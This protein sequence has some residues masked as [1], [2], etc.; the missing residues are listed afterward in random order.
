MSLR[1]LSLI[2]S[3]SLS[4]LTLLSAQQIATD[5]DPTTGG[6]RSITLADDPSPMN[7]LAATDSVEMAAD[8]PAW[9]WGVLP[10]VGRQFQW[11]LGR[12][13]AEGTMT[14]WRTAQHALAGG[15]YVYELTPDVTLTVRRTDTSGELTETY[16]F[17]NDGTSAVSL[18]DIEINTPFA[19]NYPDAP[20]CLAERCHTHIWAGGS[21][22]YVYALHMGAQPM[23]LALQL[24]E[25]SISRYAQQEKSPLRGSSNTRGILCLC[26][27]DMKL[28]P[29]EERRVVWTLFAI[30]D[31]DDFYGQ[32][33][34][35]GSVVASA[36]RYVA[37]VGDTVHISFKSNGSKPLANARR[38]ADGTQIQEIAYVIPQPGEL[39]VACQYPGGATRVE[40]LGIPPLDN[41]LSARARFIIDHQQYNA[42]GEPQDGAFLPYDNETDSLYLDWTKPRRRSDMTEG[43]ERLGMGIFLAEY[44]ARTPDEGLRADITTALRRYARFVRTGLQDPDYKTWGDVARWSKHRLYNYPWTAHLYCSMYKLTHE[45]QYIYDAYR[46]LMRMYQEAGYTFYAIDVPVRQS[47]H[48]LEEAGYLA[49]RD[50]LLQ[51]FIRQGDY[52]AEARLHFPISEVNYEQSIVAPSVA[53]LCDIYLVTREPRY[54]D[55]IREMLPVLEA[56]VGRQPSHHLSD[57]SIRH[58]DAYW[59][60]KRRL[61]GDTFPHYWSCVT[62][63]VYATYALC[64]GNNLYMERA[65]RICQQNLSLFTPDGRGY[66]AWNYS[67][68]LGGIPGHFADPMA[69]DQDFALMFLLKWSD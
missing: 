56:F 19:D 2:L 14:E 66:C 11:G 43:R 47:L 55:A 54:L 5:V 37:E 23:G 53:F 10:P 31:A 34:R 32:L 61:Y 4:A 8:A 16:T 3:Y 67:D 29:G 40:L 62:A 51:E 64:S 20:T 21:D 27:D 13:R 57:I 18:T 38:L 41:L 50:S 15:T 45:R 12:L 36:D 59:F 42:P 60:G 35:R 69:N 58:W 30:T 46:T 49:Q 26:P 44:A 39:T 7:W 48:L 22:A 52:Y 1:H 25:G 17:R 65:R 24:R 63:D 68:R 6:I 33:L 9:P 28:Q